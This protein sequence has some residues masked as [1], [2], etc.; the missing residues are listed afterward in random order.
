MWNKWH[1]QLQQW[2]NQ[3]GSTY[4]TS[5]RSLIPWCPLQSFWLPSPRQKSRRLCRRMFAVFDSVEWCMS[6]HPNMADTFP[7]SHNWA[8]WPS[9][10]LVRT[11]CCWHRIQLRKISNKKGTMV[12]IRFVVRLANTA[13]CTTE[14]N[15]GTGQYGHYVTRRHFFLQI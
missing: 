2:N 3:V 11:M 7:A 10:S 14:G 8:V 5:R 15:T 6:R 4:R 9:C 13:T 1:T 12:V